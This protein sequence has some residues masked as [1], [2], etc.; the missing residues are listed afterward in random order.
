[1]NVTKKFVFSSI[2]KHAIEEAKKSQ[3]QHRV[4]AVIFSGKRILSVAHNAVRSNKI[5][6]KWKNFYESA[7]AEAKA[8]INS[9]LNS[10][11]NL[12]GYSILVV[13][14]NKHGHLLNAKPCE[15]CQNFIDFVG[16]KVYYSDNN[17]IFK[18]TE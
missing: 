14:I 11:R 9:K 10:K 12:K 7:H 17:E 16:L 18:L 4:G 5:P 1:M 6:N 3:H 8:I 2:L 13:R 15:F